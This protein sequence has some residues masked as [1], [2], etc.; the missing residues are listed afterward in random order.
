MRSIKSSK[1]RLLSFMC[2]FRWIFKT[3]DTA[4]DRNDQSTYIKLK[5]NKFWGVIYER[6]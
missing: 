5:N 1:Q 4:N 3:G 2:P 6:K